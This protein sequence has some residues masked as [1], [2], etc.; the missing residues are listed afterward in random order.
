MLPHLAEKTIAK[1][2]IS[3]ESSHPDL[4]N[5]FDQDKL[6]KIYGG[7]A[8]AEATCVYADRGPWADVEN[9]INYANGGAA[10]EFKFEDD[11]EQV[12]L[13]KE[14]ELGIADLKTAIQMSKKI[15]LS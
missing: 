1:V 7:E 8:E 14:S 10:E 5:G 13:L 6:P 2:K 4:V 3:G 15:I 9:K 11:D 12:D